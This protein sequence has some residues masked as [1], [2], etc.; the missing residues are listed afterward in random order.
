MTP[1]PLPPLPEVPEQ[2]ETAFRYLLGW[3]FTLVEPV[4]GP[5]LYWRDIHEV[6]KGKT[7]WLTHNGQFASYAFWCT[8][9]P[10]FFLGFL[11]SPVPTYFYVLFTVIF[12]CCGRFSWEY[13]TSDK[14]VAIPAEL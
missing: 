11:F 2:V 3:C 12:G 14:A 4:L 6:P 13:D 8:V 7:G 10:F 5:L 1:A 9:L